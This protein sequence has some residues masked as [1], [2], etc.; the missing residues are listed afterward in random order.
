M[1]HLMF[2]CAAL[3]LGSGAGCVPR[4]TN[5]AGPLALAPQAASPSAP[6]APAVARGRLV[7]R[8]SLDGSTWTSATWGYTSPKLLYDGG[9]VYAVNMVGAGPGKDVARL[10]WRD[11]GGWHTGADI[12]P[13]YQPATMLLDAAGH[14]NVFVTETAGPVHH[15]RSLRPRDVTEFAEVPV[16]RPESFRYGY[17]GVGTD[18]K[19]I[20]LCG[21]DETYSMWF[22]VK[23][24]VDR[25]W[26]RPRRIVPSQKATPPWTSPV[27]PVVIPDGNVVHVIY[28]NSPDGGVHNTYNRVE[29]VA[30]DMRTGRVAHREVVA[31]GPVGEMTYGVDA[32]KG[33]DGTLYALYEAGAYVYGGKRPDIS[34]RAG[35][36]CAALRPGG[37]WERVRITPTPGNGQLFL[38]SVGTLHAFLTTS[39]NTLHF[40]S[41]D[42]G[43]A[44]APA[45]D[46]VA[47][48]GS[49]AFLYVM[50]PSSGSVIT[51]TVRGV[52]AEARATPPPGG[53]SQY[54][55]DYLELRLEGR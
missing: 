3:L 54:P 43:R 24:S 21:V 23:P 18:G 14:I 6:V 1:P 10:Y 42:S 49:G 41:S 22:A 26:R 39:T 34:E 37:V 25:P 50:K 48:D 28:S 52:Q 31:E 16:P 4:Q 20:A 11:A 45:A 47:W 46:P 35:L 27:Y 55:L 33:S 13:M 8:I 17:L 40:V 44:W 2:V 15:W 38:D 53:K 32:L 7:E 5:A 30:C 9:R 12:S 51:D 29:H 36:F 19:M